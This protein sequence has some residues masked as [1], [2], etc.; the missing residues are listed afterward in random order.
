M[1]EAEKSTLNVDYDDDPIEIETS[2]IIVRICKDKVDGQPD[3][4]EIAEMARYGGSAEDTASALRDLLNKFEEIIYK[5]RSSG[6]TK[7]LQQIRR[8]YEILRR[9]DGF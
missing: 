3:L 9:A 1:I 8:S 7:R 5:E 4:T 6:P 2:E